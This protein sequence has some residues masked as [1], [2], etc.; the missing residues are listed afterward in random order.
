MIGF[1]A[2]DKKKYLEACDLISRAVKTDK[3]KNLVL[4]YY[5]VVNGKRVNGFFNCDMNN[6]EV[7]E[8]I[9]SGKDK[10]G[11]ADGDLDIKVKMYYSWKNVIGYTYPSTIWTYINRRYFRRWAPKY[12]ARNIF[13]E[14]MHNCGFTHSKKRHSLRKHSAPYALGSIIGKVIEGL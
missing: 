1:S 2:R 3:F 8:H 5:Y 14:A 4:N 7:Y 6:R 9:M 13:H 12:I 11:D 10:Y